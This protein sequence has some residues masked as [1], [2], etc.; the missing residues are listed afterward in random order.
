MQPTFSNATYVAILLLLT[1]TGCADESADTT[2]SESGSGDDT[3]A[4][5]YPT[6]EE[7]DA[8]EP[9]LTSGDCEAPEPEQIWQMPEAGNAFLVDDEYFY[10]TNDSGIV[11]MKKEGAGDLEEV[12]TNVGGRGATLIGDNIYFAGYDSNSRVVA[13]VA[14]DGGEPV[15]ISDQM[16]SNSSSIISDGEALF[17][18]SILC[19]DQDIQRIEPDGTTTVLVHDAKCPTGASVDATHY[20]WHGRSG[21]N[22]DYVVAR[23]NKHGGDPEVLF[24][25]EGLSAFSDQGAI[26]GTYVYFPGPENDAT[27]GAF[28]RIPKEGGELEKVLEDVDATGPML[29]DS[30]AD[31]LYFSVSSENGGCVYATHADGTIKPVA[32]FADSVDFL[33]ST[34]FESPNS[35]ALDDDYLYIW[36]TFLGD[37]GFIYRVPR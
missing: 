19:S 30:Y 18:E 33:D 7:I 4:T 2:A 32:K 22:G 14:K 23:I 1:L 11:R 37:E 25:G 9:I 27:Y 26:D 13:S 16:P 35:L 21:S 15:V 24:A 36:T 20:Y 6:R 8:M 29:Y 17:T 31:K 3:E 12:A 28:L 34:I 10:F 5:G